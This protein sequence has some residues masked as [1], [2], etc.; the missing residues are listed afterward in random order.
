M[1]P[2]S[3]DDA[4][5]Y[6][7]QDAEDRERHRLERMGQRRGPDAP[8]PCEDCGGEGTVLQ[9]VSMDMAIDAGDR[10]LCGERVRVPC[11]GRCLGTGVQP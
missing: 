7:Q 6:R 3:E 2:I 8:E 10:D 5:D 11:P 1:R 9:A 4:A